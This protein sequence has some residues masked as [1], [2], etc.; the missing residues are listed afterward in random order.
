MIDFSLPE[1]L[2]AVRDSAARFAREQLFPAR[3]EAERARA[4]P[5]ATLALARAIGFDQ[6]LAAQALGGAAPGVLAHCLVA[7]ELAA[8]DAGGALRILRH[9]LALAALA[10]FGADAC[11]AL[12]GAQDASVV[13]AA[14]GHVDT[15]AGHLRASIGWICADTADAIV[16]LGR[17]GAALVRTG[18]R[19]TP[20]PGSALQASGASALAIDGP[21]AW[22]GQHSGAARRALAYLRLTLAALALGAMRQA[23]SQSR[24]YALERMAFGK[25][26]A[27]HQALA[28]LIV[29]M[30]MAL[31]NARVLLHE[32]AWRA[33]SGLPFEADAAAAFVE[34]AEAGMFVGPNG[35]QIFG[36]AGFMRDGPVEKPMRELRALSLMAAGVDAARSDA[37]AAQGSAAL[38]DAA[39]P[40]LPAARTAQAG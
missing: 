13:L 4:L 11:A 16:L 10:E 24:D 18:L 22:A 3:R 25:P 40:V 27:H 20:A 39:A 5:A 33:D 34:A 9:A 17:N 6:L 26:I 38:I 8:A 37:F 19:L 36:A 30:R 7:E 32:A 31:D 29:D 21:V 28:F 12:D 35:V 14:D 2:Q 1:D 23:C 15:S